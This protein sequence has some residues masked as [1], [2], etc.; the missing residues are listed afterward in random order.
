MSVVPEFTFGNVVLLVTTT[1]VLLV[2]PFEGS[3]T[4]TVYV[5]AALTVGEAV[6]PPAVMP[7]PVQLYV[8]PGV[9]ELAPMFPLVVMQSKISDDPAVTS[10]TVPPLLVTFTEAVSL[11]PL[12]GSVIVTV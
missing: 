7:A 2:H 9:T 1:F 6:A 12:E 5:P 11:H 4:I 10:G 8:T 3:V